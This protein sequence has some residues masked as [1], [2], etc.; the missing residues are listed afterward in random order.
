MRKYLIAGFIILFGIFYSYGQCTYCTGFDEA[1]KNPEL[2][3]IIKIDGGKSR[4]KLNK[5]PKD[6]VRFTNLKTLWLT[7]QD[8]YEIGDE[9]CELKNISSLSLAEDKL[10][11]LPECIYGMKNLIEIYLMDNNFSNEKIVE[12]R[13]RFRKANSQVKVV[14]DIHQ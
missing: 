13:D 2:V 9:L 11:D 14:F 12:I 6:I 8:F 7:K 3:T 5:I 10:I 4:V 1:F